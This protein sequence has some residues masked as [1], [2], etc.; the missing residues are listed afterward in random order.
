MDNVRNEGKLQTLLEEGKKG[1]REKAG[2]WNSSCR[3]GIPGTRQ[4]RGTYISKQF[5]LPVSL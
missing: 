4:S 2:F 3:E 5:Q 1:L